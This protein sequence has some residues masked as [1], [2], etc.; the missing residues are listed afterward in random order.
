MTFLLVGWTPAGSPRTDARSSV[1]IPIYLPVLTRVV[2]GVRRRLGAGAQ[3]ELGE[4]AR[5]VVLCRTAADHEPLGDL[6]VRE[7]L[8]EKGK[9]LGFAG[10][11]C[12]GAGSP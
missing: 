2:E 3:I 8:G 4:D 5:H 12:A 1:G 9:H 6:G 11:Q 10:R 7:T